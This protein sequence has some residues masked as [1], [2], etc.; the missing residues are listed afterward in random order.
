[1]TALHYITARQRRVQSP[2]LRE[3]ERIYDALDD[4]KLIARLKEYRWTGRPGHSV[5][6]MWRSYLAG[7]VLNLPST[8][9]LI[10]RLQEDRPLARLWGFARLPSRWTFNRFVNRLARH[11]GLVEEVFAS[12]TAVCIQ[13]K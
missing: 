11:L 9:A 8:N 6:A 13:R 3:L 10:R 2:L 12:A 7:F 1:M 4:E 5:D